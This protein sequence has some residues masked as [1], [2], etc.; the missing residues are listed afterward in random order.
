M[1]ICYFADGGSIHIE[2]WCKYF[3]DLGHDIHLITFKEVYYDNIKIH[4]INIGKISVDGGNWKS[5]LKINKVRNLLNQ[6]KPD[7][8]H[9]LYATS[10]GITGA[11]CFYNPYVITALGSDV[12]ISPNNSRIYRL[13][14][15]FAFSRANWITAMA[16]HMKTAIIHLGVDSKKISTVPFGIDPNLFNDSERLL[17]SNKFVIISTRNFEDVYN[18]PHLLKAIAKVRSTIPNLNLNLIGAGSKQHELEKLCKE[19][20]I[21]D[22]TFFIGKLPQIQI[23]KEL[24]QSHVFISV[25]KSDGNNISLNEAMACGVFPIV[26]S[27]PANTQWIEDGENGFLVEIDDVESLANRIKEIYLNYPKLQNK[28]SSLNKNI[29]EKRAIW[30]V[31]MKSVESKYFELIR[32]K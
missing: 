20:L 16:E 9:S 15:K 30:S 12:L 8:F 2:R 14:L 25:S 19:L 26:T 10:Y 7:I 27:I 21:D 13:L 3:Y 28:A 31:N 23:A 4:Y 22:C 32:N 29:I 5:L 1:K 24:N 6:I 17:N 18:I 11:L